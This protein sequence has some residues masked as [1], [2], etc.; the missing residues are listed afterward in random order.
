MAIS[1]SYIPLYGHTTSSINEGDMMT[2]VIIILKGSV[3]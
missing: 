1:C 2:F 3:N